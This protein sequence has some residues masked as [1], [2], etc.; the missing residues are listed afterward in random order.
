MG[1]HGALPG[2]QT[3]AIRML[4]VWPLACNCRHGRYRRRCPGLNTKRGARAAAAEIHKNG[5]HFPTEE[6]TPYLPAR[7]TSGRKAVCPAL[8]HTIFGR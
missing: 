3:A 6:S 4:D 1:R 7:D 2:A 5:K 8:I